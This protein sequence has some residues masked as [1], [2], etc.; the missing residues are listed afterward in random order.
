MNEKGLSETIEKGEDTFTEFKEEKAHSDDL[1]AEIVAFA[2]TEGG[3]ILLGISDKKEVRGVSNPDKE[4]L[5][6]ENV[7]RNNCEPPLTVNIEKI[8]INDEIVLG[9]YIPKGPE[10][11]YRTNRGVYYVRTSSG[12][13]QATREEL[14]RLYQATRSF[15]YD[16]L[17]VP[18]TSV[19]ELDIL[20]FRRFFERFF[21]TRIEEDLDLN[22]LLENMKILTRLDKNLVFTVGGYLLFGLNPQKELPFC[23]ITVAKFEGNEIGEAF[24]KKD[25]EGNLEEQI[26]A[27]DTV[28][29]LYLKTR[30]RI[31]GFENELKPEIPKE[32]LRELVVN[33]V[34]HRDYHIASQIRIFIFD[35]RMEVISPGKLPNR[36]TL[37]NIK[38]GV[39][40]ERNPL[41]VSYLAKMGYMTQIG[42]GIVRMIRL[43]REHT[44]KEP[45]FEERD[46]EFVVIIRRVAE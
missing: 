41:I 6:V 28:L 38:L 39:H 4:M 18:V 32:V 11:P 3:K 46:Q 42:T 21:Q 44:G 14:L 45:E 29:N 36:T 19:D 40:S 23:K 31:K 1:A 9:I 8:K 22:K 17:A 43:L 27:A 25:L 7:S 15:Y 37:E 16:E 30:V 24:E 12:K 2:N 5:R 26:K 35:N 34:A 20:Y 13:R 10:R 33:A